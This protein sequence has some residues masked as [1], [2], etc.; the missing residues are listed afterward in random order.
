M[1]HPFHLIAVVALMARPCA[2]QDTAPSAKK[3][4][5]DGTVTSH[6]KYIA[7]RDSG[8]N[9]YDNAELKRYALP[10]IAPDAPGQLYS[11]TADP[12][13][14]TNLYF[15][16]PEIVKELKGLLDASKASGRSNSKSE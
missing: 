15:K 6:W 8:G 14:T 4:E 10:D 7:H 3:P 11:F 2:A 5:A 1:Q 9:N 16:H 12:G 13:E